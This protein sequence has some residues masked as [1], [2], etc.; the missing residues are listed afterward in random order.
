MRGM[1]LSATAQKHAKRTLLIITIIFTIMNEGNK[2]SINHDILA[3]MIS[4]NRGFT[5]IELLVVIAIIGILSSVVLASLNS[6]RAKAADTKV[7][8]VMANIRTQALLY[9]GSGGGGS[10]LCFTAGASRPASGGSIF[11]DSD[12]S[13]NDL[14]DMMTSIGAWG[15]TYDGKNY[16]IVAPLS[17]GNYLC[18]DT[19]LPNQIRGTDTSGGPYSA[20]NGYGRQGA[21]GSKPFI[22]KA[23][24]NYTA[25][26]D[27][28]TG[29]QVACM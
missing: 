18:L 17:G 2:K 13:A 21:S 9:Q 14:F 25:T 12:P 28:P 20:A 4:T 22:I 10:P 23:F 24:F 27:F 6:A 19:S 11:A 3:A 7:R 29:W 5:L 16:T 26:A 15:C 1:I 8:A